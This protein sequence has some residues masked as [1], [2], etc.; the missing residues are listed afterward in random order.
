M[1]IDLLS[2]AFK[3]INI[4]HLGKKFEIKNNA[5]L[6]T[7]GIVNKILVLQR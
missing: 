4:E 3:E 7:C 5:L 1:C 6:L 2:D